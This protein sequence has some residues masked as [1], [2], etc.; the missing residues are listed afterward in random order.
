MQR[1]FKRCSRFY[2]YI[3]EDRLNPLRFVNILN[4][5]NVFGT[6]VPVFCR[7]VNM[8]FHFHLMSSRGN[9]TY[10]GKTIKF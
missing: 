3:F 2:D 8:K 1:Q 10:V 9:I 6:N 7:Y 5:T 4:G